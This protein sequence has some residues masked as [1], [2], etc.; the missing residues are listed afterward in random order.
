MATTTT[1]TS[2][3]GANIYSFELGPELQKILNTW[4][5]DLNANKFTLRFNTESISPIQISFDKSATGT[6]KSIAESVA[7]ALNTNIKDPNLRPAF[8]EP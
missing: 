4:T 8:I 6:A 3:A 7:I 1:S 5:L 2:N